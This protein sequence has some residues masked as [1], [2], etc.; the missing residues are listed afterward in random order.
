MEDQK[1]NRLIILVVALALFGGGVFAFMHYSNQQSENNESDLA[2]MENAGKPASPM[3]T[4]N[5]GSGAQPAGTAPA[6]TT[7]DTPVAATTP[8]SATAPVAATQPAVTAAA[9][10]PMATPATTPPVATQPAVKPAAA[11]PVAAQPPAAT[12]VAAP[13]ATPVKPLAAAVPPA[14]Q[15]PATPLIASAPATTAPVAVAVEPAAQPENP[16]AVGV[17]K[18]KKRFPSMKRETLVAEAKQAA[19]RQDP[20][21]PYMDSN[22][23]PMYSKSAAAEAAKEEAK[24]AVKVP[25]PPPAIAKAPKAGA[26]PRDLVPPPPPSVPG[27]GGPGELS[28][29]ELPVAPPKPT[30]AD[31]LRLA[32]VI[33]NKVILNVPS[34]VRRENKWPATISLGPGE[35]FESL[36][37]VSVDGDSVTIDEDGERT[38]KTLASIK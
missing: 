30:V 35:Q 12:P 19:G 24:E 11:P 7:P 21:M 6:A 1:R 10:T 2:A 9:V 22:P 32:A 25:P 3:S 27:V 4:A 17:E 37:I 34:S 31:K 26:T 23:F 20:M 8:P 16:N 18:L 5:N 15:A 36:S 28:L 14:A 38:V 33:G 29:N 13:P